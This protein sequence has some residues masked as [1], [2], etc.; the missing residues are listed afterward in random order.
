[1]PTQR[2]NPSPSAQYRHI[3]SGFGRGSGSRHKTPLANPAPG[4][5]TGS[6]ELPPP[7]F[8]VGTDRRS[9][10]RRIRNTRC[11]ARS[12]IFRNR[13]LRPVP[14]DQRFR[15]LEVDR[16]PSLCVLSGRTF[17]VRL[18][19]CLKSL[20]RGAHGG[21]GKNRGLAG[22][23]ECSREGSAGPVQ[24]TTDGIGTLLG[25]LAD[26]F[27]AQILISDQE[28]QAPVLLRQAV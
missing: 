19:D 1:M 7:G 15:S 11:H 18:S 14:G 20:G 28:Q 22:L 5:K 10:T 24:F 16:R 3:E 27:I 21:I 13:R 25:N 12:Q 9:N 26:L 23:D 4:P 6:K 17:Q 2:A 8:Q